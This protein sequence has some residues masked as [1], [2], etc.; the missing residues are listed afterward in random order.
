MSSFVLKLIA[1]I[2]MLI[3]HVGAVFVP[4]DTILYLIMR[5]IGRLAFPI[6]VFLI[7]EGFHHTRDVKKYLI[8]LGIFAFVSEVPFDLAFYGSVRQDVHQNVF[9][10]LFLGLLTITLIHQVEI[11][12]KHKLLLSNVINAIITIAFSFLAVLLKTDYDYAG[13]LM[14]VSFYIF[15]KKQT[16]LAIILLLISG[17]ILGGINI[18]ASLAIIPIALYNGKKG[19]NVKYIFYI[20]YPGHLLLLYLINTFL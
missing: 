8:R 7:V 5:S 17:T 2:T 13:V 3:D 11:K 12:L 10:T 9:F 18:L 16:M 19:K 4:S 15:R 6:F 1:I 20:F 14:I